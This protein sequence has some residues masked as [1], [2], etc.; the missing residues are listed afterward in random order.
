M[1]W[2]KDFGRDVKRQSFALGPLSPCVETCKH[3]EDSV[4]QSTST[5]LVVFAV[6]LS[7]ILLFGYL[8]ARLVLLGLVGM[9]FWSLP[10]DAYQEV[11]WLYFISQWS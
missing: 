6:V 7:V 3:C 10:V 4:I 1:R 5:R 9:S 8:V 11:N 2:H